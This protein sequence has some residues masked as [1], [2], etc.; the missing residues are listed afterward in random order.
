IDAESNTAPPIRHVF[1][2]V[3]LQAE[4]PSQRS[5]EVSAISARVKADDIRAEDSFDQPLPNREREENFGVRKRD[6][7]EESN[8]RF[9][10]PLAKER[11]H[12]QQLIIVDPHDIA[13]FPSLGNGV[14]ETLVRGL[15]RFPTSDAQWKTIDAV[16]TDGPQHRIRDL[17]VKD[18][19]FVR[20]EVDGDG[21]QFRE[22]CI[23]LAPC[24]GIQSLELAGPTDPQPVAL[25]MWGLQSGR[26]TADAPTYY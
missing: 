15:V 8:A 17:F 20:R 11:R 5:G 4:Q 14:G 12:A 19:D 22:L 21:A 2:R 23:D 9:G 26:E 18:V 25:L 3:H 13:R 6:M 1:A 16:V 24:V 10:K 7:E